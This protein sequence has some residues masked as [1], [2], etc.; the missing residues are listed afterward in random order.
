MIAHINSDV[1]NMYNGSSFLNGQE[2]D[3]LFSARWYFAVLTN[4][5]ICSNIYFANICNGNVCVNEIHPI[6]YAHIINS[7]DSYLYD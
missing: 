3:M 1:L 6:K 4:T 5:L 2:I 7:G